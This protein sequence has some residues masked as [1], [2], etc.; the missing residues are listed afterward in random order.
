MNVFHYPTRA[1]VRRHGPHGYATVESFRPWLRD[2]FCFCC[3]YCRYREQWSRLK[4]AFAIDHFLPV[5]LIKVEY[6]NLLYA[7]V[8]CNLGKSG[9]VLPDPTQALLES[10]VV[11]YADGRMEGLTRETREI[12]AKLG[13]NDPQE[14]EARVMWMGII[15]LAEENDPALFQRLMGYPDDLPNLAQLRPPGGNHCPEGIAESCYVKRQNGSLPTI[16]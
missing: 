15:A 14:V 9:Q 11:V 2:E 6:D 12:I 3:V 5:S 13:L 8:A 10:R 16:A 4:G 1:H 7:C